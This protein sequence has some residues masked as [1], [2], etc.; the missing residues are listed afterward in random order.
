MQPASSGVSL[1]DRQG[2]AI[3]TWKAIGI[4][5]LALGL[6]AFLSFFAL[7]FAALYGGGTVGTATILL[8]LAAVLIILGFVGVAIVYNQQSAQ[9][10]DLSDALTRAGHPGVDVRRLQVGRPVPS[11]QGVELR[12]RKAR[13]DS[14]ARWLLVDAY[15]YAA[16]P[17][18]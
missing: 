3:V 9:R 13:D 11:P 12:L 8:V 10:N 5:A 2:S 17:A 1:P 4:T 14:G 7:M 18:R 15:A 6:V 16:P